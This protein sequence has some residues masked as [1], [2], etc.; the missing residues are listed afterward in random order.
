M[1]ARERDDRPQDAVLAGRISDGCNF[2]ASDRARSTSIVTN[3]S[4]DTGTGGPDK[5]FSA[6]STVSNSTA[7]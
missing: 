3:C 7:V 4:S 5:S 2:L 6:G 1:D